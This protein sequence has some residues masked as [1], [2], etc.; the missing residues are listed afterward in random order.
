MEPVQCSD[1]GVFQSFFYSVLIQWTHLCGCGDV[2]VEYL[3]QWRLY[4]GKCL[5]HSR[6]LFGYLVS[7]QPF[8]C[9]L[10]V[11]VWGSTSILHHV[12]S[13]NPVFKNVRKDKG[14]TRWD[15]AEWLQ[16]L[17]VNAQWW[18]RFSPGFNLSILRHRKIWGAADEAVLNTLL[19]FIKKSTIH[20][21][22]T[23]LQ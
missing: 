2:L 6:V 13:L 11:K 7:A 20:V 21:C 1:V 9:N 16:H 12:W 14:E 15:Q 17:T 19:Y 3:Q 10:V 8:P 23:T 5:S 4:L 22:I 18:S